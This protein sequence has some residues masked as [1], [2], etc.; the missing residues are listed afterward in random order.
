[1]GSWP[2]SDLDA[3]L[4]EVRAVLGPLL[5]ALVQVDCAYLLRHPRTPR[6]YQSGV[7]YQR[8]APGLED[9]QDIPTC[10]RR[11]VGDCEDLGCWLVAERRVFD[12][13]PT[14]RPNVTMRRRKTGGWLFH[15]K[16]ISSRFGVEDP[17]ALLGMRGKDG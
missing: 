13:D 16:D 11:R 5:E 2:A 8:E 9:W 6:L 4:P 17:S 7:R 10:L 1:M 14:A 3:R 15:I 12:R